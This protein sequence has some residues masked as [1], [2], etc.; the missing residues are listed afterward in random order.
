MLE[1]SGAALKELLSTSPPHTLQL[2]GTGGMGKTMHLN[3]L[4]A[5]M[6]VPEPARL[7]CAIVD[8][9]LLQLGNAV[10]WPWLV[11][12]EIAHQL[13]QQLYEPL[14]DGFLAK[15]GKLRAYLLRPQFLGDAIPGQLSLDLSEADQIAG[16][17]RHQFFDIIE[18]GGVGS[19]LL[20]VFDTLERVTH[21]E[22]VRTTGDPSEFLEQMSALRRRLPQ[23]RMVLSGRFDLRDELDDLESRFGEMRH[24]ELQRLGEDASLR[25]LR[26]KRKLRAGADVIAAALDSANAAG[27]GALPFKLALLADAIAQRP[28]TTAEEIRELRE[29]ELIYVIKRVVDHMDDF[30]LRWM[31]LFGVIP[32]LLS[33]QFAVEVMAPYLEQAV[34]GDSDVGQALANAGAAVSFKTQPDATVEADQLWT[35]LT[36]YAASYSWVEM[37]APDVLRFHPDVIGPLRDLVSREPVF[38]RINAD[39]VAYFERQASAD[40]DD[41]PRMLREVLFH[42]ASVEGGLPGDWRVEVRRPSIDPAVAAA[43]AEQVIELGTEPDSKIGRDVVAEAR[44]ERALATLRLASAP[45]APRGGVAWDQAREDVEA[46]ERIQSPRGPRLIAARAALLINDADAS[47][48]IELLEPLRSISPPEDRLIIHIRHADALAQ[49]FSPDA[50]KQYRSAL[51]DAR[52]L[53]VREE[54]LAVLAWRRATALDRRD[55]LTAAAAA[56]KEALALAPAGGPVYAALSLLHGQVSLRCGQTSAARDSAAVAVDRGGRL[57]HDARLL[58]VAAELATWAPETALELVDDAVLVAA[59]DDADS[60]EAGIRLA[61]AR[62][63]R[64]VVR[65]QLRDIGGAVEDLEAAGFLWDSISSEGARRTHLK[66]AEIYL[67]G[68]ADI[69]RAKLALGRAEKVP[70]DQGGEDG[71]RAD[72]LRAEWQARAGIGQ[73]EALVDAALVEFATC[74]AP[75]GVRARAGLDGLA[76]GLSRPPERWLQEMNARLAE[77]RP[78]QPA[79][80]CSAISSVARCSTSTTRAACA[81]SGGSLRAPASRPTLSGLRRVTSTCGSCALPKWRG[82]PAEHAMLGG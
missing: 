75:P 7:S 35:K 74:Q 21:L 18:T 69:D 71:A 64:G 47:A 8:L 73:P 3:A 29:P 16:D 24:L 20:L 27:E 28:D 51:R 79:S 15:H 46:A 61:Q 45:D 72:L 22:D 54:D 50:D 37:V 59:G 55:D 9:D 40:P 6:A 23:A 26:R 10:R 76:L 56:C 12:V 68:P 32:R 36:R 66:I 42:K 49:Q 62:E 48:A 2:F 33:R 4:V 77:V 13:N 1:S 80:S 31:L 30:R 81:N 58:R 65:A 5:R 39:A 60:A 44:V 78:A 70:G 63:L 52:K 43:L 25:Y 38:K 53:G 41:R 17:V 67:R 57:A 14:F 82:W 19:A 11:L 34:R